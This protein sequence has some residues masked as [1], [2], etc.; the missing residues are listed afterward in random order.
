MIA[1]SNS[2]PPM[3]LDSLDDDAAER[4][5]RDLGGAAA[6][7]D[8]HVAGG[9]V[10]REPGADRGGHR[11]FDHEHRLAGAGELGGFLHR[12]SLDAR[13]P[14][15]DADHHA[16]LRPLALV[17]ALDE[18]AQHLLADV[19]VGDHAV[20]QRADGLD[21]AGRAAEHALRLDADREH[22][23]VV[24]VDRDDR[25]LVEHDPAPSHVDERVGGAEVDGHVAANDGGE[26]GLRHRDGA[27]DGASDRRTGL[28]GT[29]AGHRRVAIAAESPPVSRA[30]TALR[31]LGGHQGRE[32]DGDLALGGLGAV[33]AVHEV[34]GELEGEIAPDR[35]RARLPSGS[36]IPI[37]VRTTFHVSWPPS[38]TIATSGP[39]GDERHEV[40]E[41]R[42]LA[43]LVVV[44]AGE[45]RRRCVRSSIATIVSSLRSSR[46]TISPTSRRST[47]SGLHR[48]RVRL[49]MR[50]RG[51]RGRGA[52]EAA[53]RPTVQRA[54]RRRPGRPRPV[55]S[56]R[57]STASATSVD[58]LHP[59]VAHAEVARG[60]RRPHRG[61]RAR[62]ARAGTA[63]TV[64]SAARRARRASRA[65]SFCWSRPITSVRAVCG[66]SSS[67][68]ARS[69]C[70][71][72]T[73]CVPSS[74]DERVVTDDL[75]PTRRV[76][77]RERGLARCRRRAR[78]RGS[79][80]PR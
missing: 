20:L 80:R 23:A 18:V 62:G 59:V 17:H 77:R 47:A 54:R 64:S 48:T 36:S 22:A 38:T 68:A 25:R 6:D 72:A 7:V 43:V 13:D 5:H 50:R 26:P 29:V 65:R 58:D 42:L 15:R 46:P 56:M 63:I 19:E 52:G 31:R 21:V 12:A 4:D 8:D 10:H 61:S 49:L 16:W 35:A 71:P 30:V 2:S 33:G 69:A 74:S 67:S 41:E 37:R 73:F 28:A 57:A 45:S 11:L 53:D 66:N 9:L 39:R 34:L 55:D 14:R 78:G 70:A 79:T 24:G 1:S 75:E 60:G 32:E 27:P 76:H 3:R 40:A 51:Y 44:A